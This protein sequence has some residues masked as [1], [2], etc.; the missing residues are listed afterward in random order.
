MQTETTKKPKF[1]MDKAKKL[2]NDS[3]EENNE[4]KKEE[5][6]IKASEVKSLIEQLQRQ[7][8]KLNQEFN[9]K[10]TMMLKTQGAIEIATVQLQGLEDDSKPTN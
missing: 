6:V 9:E 8:Q 4:E 7:H 10:Q 5:K 2:L 3:K 1:D